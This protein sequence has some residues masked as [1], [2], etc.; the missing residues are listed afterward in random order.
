M[1]A[2]EEKQ[3]HPKEAA[4]FVNR[5]GAKLSSASRDTTNRTSYCYDAMMLE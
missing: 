2:D 1:K 3:F 5:F 4:T